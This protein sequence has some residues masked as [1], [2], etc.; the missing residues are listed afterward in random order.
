[1][2]LKTIAEVE[3]CEN[4]GFVL[5]CGQGRRKLSQMMTFGCHDT[6]PWRCHK[7]ALETE[8]LIKKM[9]GEMQMSL[10]NVLIHLQIQLDI[11][12]FFSLV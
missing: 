12:I 5:K 10:Y 9:A 4:A 7:L 2:L 6:V 11:Y 3:K 1:M 8:T